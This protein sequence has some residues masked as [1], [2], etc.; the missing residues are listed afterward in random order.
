[1]RMTCISRTIANLGKVPV[2]SSLAAVMASSRSA[3]AQGKFIA[4]FALTVTSIRLEPP[5]SK[6]E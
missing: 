2:A 4:P 5:L 3:T 1:M 6:E